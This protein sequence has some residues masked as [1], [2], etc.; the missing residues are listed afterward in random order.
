MT[1]SQGVCIWFTGRSGAG[2]ST[3]TRALLPMLAESRRT[4]SVLDVVPLLKKRWCERTSEGKLLRKAFV[5]SEIVN[6]GWRRWVGPEA[7]PEVSARE[8]G[9]ILAEIASDHRL[10]F[11]AHYATDT[12][13][14]RGGMDGAIAALERVDAFLAGVLERLPADRTLLVVSDHGNIEDVRGGHTRN[15]ALGLLFGPEAGARAKGLEGL[16]DVTPRALDWLSA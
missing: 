14:H 15:P 8:A 7:V 9:V 3:I 10:T 6:E 12:A 2:K 5:A 1:E 4:V 16:M 11:F 13:G